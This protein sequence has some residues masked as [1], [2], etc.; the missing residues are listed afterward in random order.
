VAHALWHLLAS[1]WATGAAV[2]SVSAVADP[3]ER[4]LGAAEWPEPLVVVATC[5]TLDASAV[6][7]EW[8]AGPVG[9]GPVTVPVVI[10][11]E[12]AAGVHRDLYFLVGRFHDT[13]AGIRCSRPTAWPGYECGRLGLSGLSPPPLRAGVPWAGACRAFHRLEAAYRAKST[14][15]ALRSTFVVRLPAPIHAD[16]CTW[17]P[18]RSFAHQGR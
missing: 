18:D 14:T 3:G 8:A 2:A 11:P 13:G 5:P 12:L 9:S 15:A 7:A 16:A 4:V 1:L 10:R 6:V 17:L